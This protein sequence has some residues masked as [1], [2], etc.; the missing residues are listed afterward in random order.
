MRGMH[1]GS[2]LA[3]AIVAQLTPDHESRRQKNHKALG[4]RIQNARKH[5]TYGFLANR[6]LA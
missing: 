2:S 1:L 5:K 3:A 4:S 6:I